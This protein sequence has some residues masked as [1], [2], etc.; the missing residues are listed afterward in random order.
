MSTG[1]PATIATGGLELRLRRIP[2]EETAWGSIVDSYPQAEVY[3]SPAWIGYLVAAH[4]VVPVTAELTEG[5]QVVGHF[6]GATV[7]RFG[8]RVLGS[9]LQGWG[10]QAMGF[11]LSE[12]V[13]MSAAS[14]ALLEFAYGELRCVHVEL[15]DRV[16]ASGDVTAS[17]FRAERLQSAIV[18][19][20]G[21]EDDVLAQ[22]SKSTRYYARRAARNGLVM[23]EAAGPGFADEYYEQLVDV[24]RSKGL[25]PTYD[26]QRVRQLIDALAPSG[27]LLL[28]RVRAPDGSKVGTNIS[29]GRNGRAVLWGAAFYRSFAKLNP[30]EPLQYE[31]IR[32]WQA[33]GALLYDM[34]GDSPSK[35]RFSKTVKPLYRLRHSRFGFFEYGRNA[36]KTAF[37]ARQR[38]AGRRARDKGTQGDQID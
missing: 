2:Y 1:G 20:S 15:G 16:M 19:L 21:S 36:V 18:D 6:V 35:S 8:L 32:L 17:P 29:L 33:R 28:V 30:V 31:S 3:H 7:R 11:L 9:P 25:V 5:D 10:T 4:E 22:M 13:D 23:E 27:Q 38:L 12:G 26:V 37:Y 14:K 24:F 34:A